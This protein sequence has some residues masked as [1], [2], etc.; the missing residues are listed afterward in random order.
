MLP[1]RG[2]LTKIKHPVPMVVV[3]VSIATLAEALRHTAYRDE[4]DFASRVA[5]YMVAG[6]MV[7]RNIKTGQY[8]LRG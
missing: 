6:R 8:R 7:Y 3:A 2:A 4:V 1:G 5:L